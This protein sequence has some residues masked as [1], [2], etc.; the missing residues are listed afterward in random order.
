MAMKYK[1]ENIGFEGLRHEEA[2]KFNSFEAQ[3]LS[4]GLIFKASLLYSRAL[5]IFFSLWY[6]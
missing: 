1:K 6:I 4:W 2:I 3:E 5:L